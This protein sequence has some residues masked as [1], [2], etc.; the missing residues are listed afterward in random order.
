MSSVKLASILKQVRAFEN[1]CTYKSIVQ[2]LNSVIPY[3]VCW[4]VAYLLLPTYPVISGVLIVFSAGF[5]VRI[6]II[7]HDCGHGSFFKSKSAMNIVGYVC[8]IFTFTPFAAW[9]KTHSIHH[10]TSGNLDH[11]GIGDIDVLTIRE[12]EALS[13]MKKLLYRINRNVLVAIVFG[14]FLLFMFVHRIPFYFRRLRAPGK[15]VHLTN[16]GM[17]L[18]YGSLGLML[19]WKRALI[20]HVPVLWLASISAGFLFYVQHQFE[21]TYWENDKEWDYLT[22]ALQGSSYLQLPKI[23]QFFS[24]NIGFHHVHHFAPRVPNYRLEDCHNVLTAYSA[25]EPMTLWDAIKTLRLGLWDETAKELITFGE[26]KRRKQNCNNSIVESSDNIQVAITDP[27]I[28]EAADVIM[29]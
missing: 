22:A 11:R 1:P 24:G 6:F 26:A 20:V 16:L 3:M 14:P 28:P 13:P 4:Y 9:Q 2:I 17:L 23:L 10:A 19:D 27:I 25:I 18:V 21:E 29:N 12:Y 15:S 5:L 7:Q 8:G